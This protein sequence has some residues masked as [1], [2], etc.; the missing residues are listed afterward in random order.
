MTPPIK[1]MRP[2]P[3]KPSPSD[4]YTFTTLRPLEHLPNPS[5][6]LAYL[7]RLRNDA[8]I[9]AV[10]RKYKWT[11]PVLAEMEPIGNTDE[12]SRTLGRNWDKGSVIEVRL[13]TDAYDGYRDY[14]TVR[15]TM[16]HELAHMVYGEHDRDFWELCG[17]LEKE[18]EK[19][20]WRSGGRPLTDQ[21]FYEPPEERQEADSGVG[22]RGGVQKLGMGKGEEA[23]KGESGGGVE[24]RR[25]MM[26]RAA[27][28][29]L[30][31][32]AASSS[33]S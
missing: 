26:A 5:R 31:R 27:E 21:V 20:D 22:W 17:R 19:A 25:E 13:R 23:K 32:L 33:K 24:S 2:A 16:A 7:D 3:S 11:V 30:K 1:P 9:K 14:K 28:E 12:K 18:I 29:R 8:G 10:M 6:S 15:K 4:I